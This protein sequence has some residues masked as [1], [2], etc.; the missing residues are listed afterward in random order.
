MDKASSGAGAAGPSHRTMEIGVAAGTAVFALIIIGG[1]V[2]AGINWDSSGP[3]AGFFPF[4][5]ALFVLVASIVNLAQAITAQK[6]EKIFATWEQLRRVASV[7]A[8]TT[9]YVWLVPW[10]GIYVS[11]MLLIGVFMKWLGRYR[12]APVFA[13][14]IGIP[15]VTF[16][17][18]ERWFLVPLPKGP[19][20]EWLGF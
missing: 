19:I 16:V 1:S 13:V 15:I 8:P 6:K 2:K 7:V 10:I 17:V 11:S 9:V 4:Y 14:A 12:W 20:E 18:F 3:R 5:I